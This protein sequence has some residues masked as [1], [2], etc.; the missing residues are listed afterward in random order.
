M[1]GFS[2]TSEVVQSCLTL[3]DPV[4]CSLPTPPSMEYSSQE[5]WSGLPF[6]SPGDL[7]DPGIKPRSPTLQADALPS[8]PLGKPQSQIPF[9]IKR[10][11][12]SLEEWM[13]PVQGQEIDEPGISYCIR[14]QRNDQRLLGSHQKNSVTP[15]HWL[16]NGERTK[17]KS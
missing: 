4:D 9:L 14:N 16:K 6:H 3:C 13:I 2:N 7:P 15:T 11:Q 1:C 5:P 12:G 10:N 17:M 8:E